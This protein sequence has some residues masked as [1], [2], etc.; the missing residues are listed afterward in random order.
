MDVDR[1]VEAGLRIAAMVVGPRADDDAWSHVYRAILRCASS[2]DPERAAGT[3]YDAYVRKSIWRARIDAKRKAR[4][5]ALR[6]CP[7]AGA[8]GRATERDVVSEAILARWESLSPEA[9]ARIRD[10]ATDLD[11]AVSRIWASVSYADGDA[12]R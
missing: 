5:D 2:W 6:N 12:H 11:D 1:L 9:M 10:A 8:E 3:T 4:K 7:L